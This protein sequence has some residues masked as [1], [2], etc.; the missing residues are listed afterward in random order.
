M[1]VSI[2]TYIR[3]NPDDKSF[4]APPPP[5]DPQSYP[6]AP[7]LLTQ[8]GER[9]TGYHLFHDSDENVIFFMPPSAWLNQPRSWSRRE[10]TVGLFDLRAP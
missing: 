8:R 6:A 9:F 2:G 10:M 5:P 7:V 3:A 4:G 1:P